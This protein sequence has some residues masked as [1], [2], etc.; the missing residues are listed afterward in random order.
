MNLDGK[1]FLVVGAGISGVA[2]AELLIRRGRPVILYDGKEGLDIEEVRKKSPFLEQ[3][4]VLAGELP[5]E[6]VEAC[7]VA[8]LSPGVPMDIPAVEQMRAAGLELWGEIELAYAFEQGKVLAVTGTNGKTTTTSLLGAI[9]EHAGLDVKVVGNIG[10]PYT[11]LVSGTTK[12]SVTVAEISSFQLETVHEFCPQVSAILNITPDHLN[13]HHTM[14]NYR[15]AKERIAA[16]QGAGQF[17]ILNYEDAALKEFSSKV[18]AQIVFFSSKR[19]LGQGIYLDNG[20]IIWAWDEKK[21]T[22][23]HVKELKLIGMHNYENVMAAAAMALVSGVPLEKIREALVTFSA[24]EHRIEY[25]VTKRGVRFYNDSKGTN[26][27]AAIQ[28]V[29]AMEWPTLLIGGGYDKDSE[30]EDWINAFDGK[31]KKL[32][33]LGA[34]REKIRDTAVRLGYPENDIILTDSLQEAVSAC[35]THAVSGDAV[36]LSPA[37]A[38]WGMFQNYEQRGKIFKE[39]ARAL[40]G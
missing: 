36:L 2:A 18:N 34:T 22:V 30:Y 9:M 38:S 28:A 33:L 14:D 20:K 10:V 12:D 1:K 26:P 3:V 37:C 25:V 11:S 23:C 32:V 17:C 8:V 39:L 24:V 35:F 5:K 13:R 21:E 40:E 29:R 7:D 19:E 31:V 6:A 27:D 15:Q 4:E 16:N